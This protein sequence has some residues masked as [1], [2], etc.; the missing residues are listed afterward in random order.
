MSPRLLAR[1]GKSAERRR[2]LLRTPIEAQPE[3]EPLTTLALSSSLGT[4][5]AMWGPLLDALG[6]AVAHLVYDHR[7]HGAGPVPPGPYSLAD[8]AG[9]VLQRI[10]AR[11]LQRVSF[12]GVSL[13]GMVGMWLAAHHPERIERL[14]LCN[15]AAHLDGAAYAARAE[16]VRSAGTVAVVADAVLARWLTPDYAAEHPEVAAALRAQLDHT[17]PEGY[18]G[19]CEAIAAMDLR[20]DLARIRA[21]TLCIAGREDPATPPEHLERIAEAIPGAE[22]HVLSPA[23]HLSPVERAATVAELV[24]DHLR[25]DP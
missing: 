13:G 10:D 18:A 11:G 8:L 17:P 12:C 24:L 22:L 16:Q 5:A 4:T 3:P 25:S 23:A 20:A 2:E 9:D 1:P 14:V 21:P 19:C 6:D 7:G 15:T